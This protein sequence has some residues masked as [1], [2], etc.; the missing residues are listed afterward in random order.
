MSYGYNAALQTYDMNVV[1]CSRVMPDHLR[2]PV[3]G[4][5]K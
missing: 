3:S 5:Q 2:T 4:V 1:L